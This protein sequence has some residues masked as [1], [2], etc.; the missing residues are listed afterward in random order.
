MQCVLDHTS[1]LDPV[2]IIIIVHLEIIFLLGCVMSCIESVLEKRS[3]HI[4]NQDSDHNFSL[5]DLILLRLYQGLLV[6]KSVKWPWIKLLGSLQ[7]NRDIW[8]KSLSY[9]IFSP[10]PNLVQT[11]PKDCLQVKDVQWPCIKFL[12]QGRN[13]LRIILIW[14]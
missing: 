1:H 7:G 4:W 8:E 5:L 3:K 12:C 2:W 14:T 6:A 11:L 9:N 10:R 13:I